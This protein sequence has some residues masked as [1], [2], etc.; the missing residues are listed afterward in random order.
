M[1]IP[2][3][4]HSFLSGVLA[5]ILIPFFPLLSFFCFAL[6]SYVGGFLPFLE[7]RDLLLVFSRCSVQIILHVDGA[8]VMNLWAKVSA[9]S[10]SSAILILPHHSV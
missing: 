2:F 3:L 4:F 10:Y 6:L 8:G 1:Q 5:L 7:A 9:M